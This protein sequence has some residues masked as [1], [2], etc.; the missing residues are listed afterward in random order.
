MTVKSIWSG[1]ISFG[2]VVIPVRLG[3]AVS[4]EN[5]FPLHQVRRSD[6]SRI[7]MRRYAEADG[8]DGPEIA[9][10]DTVPGFSTGNGTVVLVEDSDYDLAFGEKNRAAKIITFIPAGSVPRVAHE[11][12]YLVEPGKGGEKAYELLATALAR[13]GK[14]AVISIAVR[15]REALALLSP[16][17][18]GYLTLERLQWGAS[19]RQPDFEAPRTGVT[20]AEIDLA[21]NLVTQLAKPFDWAAQEDGSAK[22]LADVIQAKAEAGQVTGTAQAPGTAAPA[23][24]A[25]LL[26][27]SVEAAK[28]KPAVRKRAPRA[29]SAAK[30]EAA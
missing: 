1:T 6:G 20:E 23:G 12:T 21:E 7:R 18:D 30:K 24:L 29:K 14:A 15:K 11:A 8:P 16:T 26:R 25:E 13:T 19:I 5:D 9:F 10:A 28:P 3:P 22:A 4:A 2:M 17:G 27:A